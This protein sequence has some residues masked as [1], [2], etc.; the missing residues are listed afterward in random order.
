M[1]PPP[2]PEGPAAPQL[3]FSGQKITLAWQQNNKPKLTAAATELTGN[4]VS[5]KA[6]MKHVAAEFYDNG[7]VVARLVAPFVEADEKT[8]VVTASGGVTITSAV[9]GSTIQ[10]VKADWV[11]WYSREDKLVGDGGIHARGP[12]TSIDASAFIADTRLRT[13][14]IMANPSE[15]RA[16]IGK[17]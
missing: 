15:A 9:P 2:K 11:R 14:K 8:R 10:T 12:V 13:I 6:A 5:G 7:K 17:H 16:V 3:K 4:T 1:K